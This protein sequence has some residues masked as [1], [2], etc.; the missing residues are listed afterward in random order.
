[1]TFYVVALE[2]WREVRTMKKET[3]SISEAAN[4]NSNVNY[5]SATDLNQIINRL[6]KVRQHQKGRYMALCPAHKDRS[7]SLS[8]SQADDGRI[9]MHCFAGCHIED[10]CSAIG[11][12]LKD[13][14]P[15]TER[16]NYST[17]PDWKRQRYQ[18]ALVR[19]HMIVEMA[20]ADR[21]K[22]LTLSEADKARVLKAIEF[23]RLMEGA[24][25][26]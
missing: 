6:E 21:A 19:E 26:G 10:I 23:I 25:H 24:N 20:K 11:L 2:L 1:M 13:L 3:T 22:G 8:L 4:L 5:S 9:L 16:Q 17:I 18:D 15:S 12:E 7:P 14:F